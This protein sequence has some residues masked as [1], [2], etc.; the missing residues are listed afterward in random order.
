LDSAGVS[1][2]PFKARMKGE[3]DAMQQKA[4]AP[5][6]QASKEVEALKSAQNKAQLNQG[7][8]R[9]TYVDKDGRTQNLASQTKNVQGRAVYQVGA[10]WVDSQVQAV[11]N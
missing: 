9:M 5:S 2:A 4:G 11:K 1:A 3:Y 7:A 6:V 8:A 10:N